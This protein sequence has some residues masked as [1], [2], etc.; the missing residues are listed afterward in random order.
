MPPSLWLLL[1]GRMNRLVGTVSC[2]SPS[3]SSSSR[4]FC[5]N[6]CLLLVHSDVEQSSTVT[7]HTLF[8]IPMF[9]GKSTVCCLDVLLTV[10]AWVM[11]VCVSEREKERKWKR[12]GE[13]K[14]ERVCVFV[15]E[16]VQQ[17]QGMM[18]AQ[19]RSHS[20]TA[21]CMYYS[22]TSALSLFYL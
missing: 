11:W 22:V 20:V 21:S 3:S 8:I 13:R 4:C 18:S 15:R 9:V 2:S 16:R 17:D 12:W 5:L 14:T 19:E 6:N 7:V 10:R 1:V